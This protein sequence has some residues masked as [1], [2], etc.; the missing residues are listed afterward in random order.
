MDW[1]YLLPEPA[2]GSANN[3]SIHDQIKTTKS[4]Q[5]LGQMPLHN[6]AIF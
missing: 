6:T 1:V 3:K 5:Y 2:R 4:K